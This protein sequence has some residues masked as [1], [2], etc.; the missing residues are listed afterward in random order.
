M[1]QK[2]SVLSLLGFGLVCL[3]LGMAL[4]AHRLIGL[5]IMD[6]SLTSDMPLVRETAQ[7][8]V[9]LVRWA[10]LVLGAAGLA[11]GA[12]WPWISAARPYRRFMA[13]D[14]APPATYDRQL[15]RFRGPSAAVMVLLI[16]LSALYLTQGPAI[17]SDAQLGW[18]NREDG[19][20]EY[21]QAGFLLLASAVSLGI[22]LRLRGMRARRAM[23]AFL[24]LLF[25]AMFGEEISWGQRILGFD[26]PENLK[27][28][29][30]QN[31]VN[32]HNMYGYMFDHLFILLFFVW[33]CVVPLLYQVSGFFRQV[34]RMIGLPVPSAGLAVGM[35]IA[36]LCQDQIVYR[37]TEGIP[38]LRLA[39]LREF[40]SAAAF[41]LLMVEARRGLLPASGPRG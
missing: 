17:F 15:T 41:L 29:N 38:G 20:L 9:R 4:D 2:A 11:L 32:L 33:G 28:L 8:E 12:L 7:L 27:G 39:E 16:V 40:L 13:W 6:A 21:A 36:T 37:L 1:S 34:F 3:V 24:A 22:A 23:H 35:L 25:F 18:I 5:G 31:E 30:V 10:L 26:T 14:L 19:V